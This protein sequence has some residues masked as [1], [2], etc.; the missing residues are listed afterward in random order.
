MDLSYVAGNNQSLVDSLEEYGCDL[1]SLLYVA[2]DYFALCDELNLTPR[3]ASEVFIKLKNTND[4][5]L[6]KPISPEIV[7][8]E[9]NRTNPTRLCVENKNNGKNCFFKAIPGQSKVDKKVIIYKCESC[10]EEVC[11]KRPEVRDHVCEKHLN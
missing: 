9:N 5:S 4:K 8:F 6:G 11:V 1:D 2:K 7:I 10:T 3:Q